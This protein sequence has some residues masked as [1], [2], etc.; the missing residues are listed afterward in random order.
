MYVSLL[1][2]TISGLVSLR[3]VFQPLLIIKLSAAGSKINSGCCATHLK[4]LLSAK[5]VTTTSN[6]ASV[7]KL[8]EVP[9]ATVLLEVYAIYISRLLSRNTEGLLSSTGVFHSL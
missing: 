6:C 8:T 9:L 4:L 5:R 3:F 7:A 1:S 2:T